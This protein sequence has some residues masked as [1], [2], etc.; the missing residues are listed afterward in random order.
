[1]GGS[2]G[3]NITLIALHSHTKR[4]KGTVLVILERAFARILLEYECKSTSE[5][6]VV[7]SRELT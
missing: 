3:N 7:V 4:G 6:G 5:G 2:R 1:M